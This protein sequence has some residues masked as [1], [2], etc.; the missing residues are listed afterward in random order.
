V[1]DLLFFFVG[2]LI[3]MIMRASWRSGHQIVDPGT[4]NSLFSTHAALDDLRLVIRPSP[5][6]QTTSA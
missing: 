4:F 1:H 2:G 3:A 6:S 5:G